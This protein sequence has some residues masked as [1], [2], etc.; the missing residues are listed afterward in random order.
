M[1]YQ[2]ERTVGVKWLIAAPSIGLESALLMLTRN[3]QNIPDP[4]SVCMTAS[5]Y[6][7]QLASGGSRPVS[8]LQFKLPGRSDPLLV[9][10]KPGRLDPPVN[11]AYQFGWLE[12]ASEWVVPDGKIYD[13]TPNTANTTLPQS[14]GGAKFP[15]TFPVNFGPSTGGTL[16][17]VNN[18]LY[19]AKPV[20]KITGPVTNPKINN[21]LTGQY[22]RVNLALQS[23]DVLTIDTGSRVVRLNGVNRNNALDVGS[24]LFTIPVGGVNLSFSST[25]GGTVA[26]TAAVYTLDTYSVV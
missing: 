17:A 22:I 2:A 3:W 21:P 23:G 10:G 19:P 7:M 24:S 15:W 25:D 12:I 20:F 8:A 4:S 13:A 26:G 1:S 16:A 5:D 9:L 11:S 14:L 18:G 6:L